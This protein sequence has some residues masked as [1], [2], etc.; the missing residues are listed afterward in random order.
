MCDEWTVVDP[1][2]RVVGIDAS[3]WVHILTH[4]PDMAAFRD[5]IKQ[6]IVRPDVIVHQSNGRDCYSVFDC[7]DGDYHQLYLRVVVDS[8]P[9][10]AMVVTAHI[11]DTFPPGEIKWMSKKSTLLF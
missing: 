11:S 1:L 5:K 7:G 2:N 3:R 4:H 9:P 8:R 6:A 10:R